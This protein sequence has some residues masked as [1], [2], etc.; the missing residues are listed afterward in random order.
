[1]KKF[2]DEAHPDIQ[3]LFRKTAVPI[4]FKA[5]PAEAE[6]TSSAIHRYNWLSYNLRPNYLARRLCKL[7]SYAGEYVKADGFV[8]SLEERF[9]P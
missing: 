9:N 6:R 4:D 5:D 7:G 1:V 3:I 2:T 8:K